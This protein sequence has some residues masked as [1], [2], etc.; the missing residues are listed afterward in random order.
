M[1]LMSECTG[2]CSI[3]LFDKKH[4]FKTDVVCRKLNYK[5]TAVLLNI[6]TLLL[7]LHV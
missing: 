5:I 2:L 7:P 3:A 1:V 6:W 4:F